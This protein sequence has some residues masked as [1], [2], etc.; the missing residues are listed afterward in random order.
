MERHWYAEPHK[1]LTSCLQ[2]WHLY[3]EIIR[4]GCLVT[5]DLISIIREV[6]PRYSR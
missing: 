3:V 2:T 6:R 4:G 1:A 5:G